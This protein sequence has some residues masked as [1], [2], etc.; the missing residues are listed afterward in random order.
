MR[1]L[2]ALFFSFSLI[3]ARSNLDIIKELFTNPNFDKAKYLRGEAAKR[4]HDFYL[5]NFYISDIVPLGKGYEFDVFRVSLSSNN[6]S[7]HLDLYIYM[8]KDAVYAVRSL[9]M[10][11]ILKNLIYH[12]EN[13]DD[14]LKKDID[15][16]NLKL[17]LAKDSELI[18]FAQENLHEFERVFEIYSSNSADKDERIERILKALHFSHI[19]NDEGVFMLVIGGMLD[20]IVGFFRAEREEDAP[21]MHENLYIMIEKIAPKWYLFKMT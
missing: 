5:K 4:N 10:T 16:K 7:E 18:K 3:F 19:E 17:T 2:V 8:L 1:V 21:L 13:I 14:S 20:N 9:A 6:D 15:L 12:Y 11:G